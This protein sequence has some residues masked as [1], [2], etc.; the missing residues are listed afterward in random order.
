[1]SHIGT[2]I[3]PNLSSPNLNRGPLMLML[4]QIHECGPL[5]SVHVVCVGAEELKLS[6][7]E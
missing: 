7:S 2:S 6:M 4:I 5:H 3:Y 1:M